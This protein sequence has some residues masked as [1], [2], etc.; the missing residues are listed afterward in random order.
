[1]MM[2]KICNKL[3]SANLYLLADES[4]TAY[5]YISSLCTMSSLCTVCV[6]YIMALPS[7]ISPSVQLLGGFTC[8]LYLPCSVPSTPGPAN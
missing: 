2:Y 3:C 1:M 8:T 7:K 6:L 5:G 4:S